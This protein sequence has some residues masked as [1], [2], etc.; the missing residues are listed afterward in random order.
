MTRR[1]HCGAGRQMMDGQLIHRSVYD[2][3][4]NGQLNAGNRGRPYIPKTTL[5][6]GQLWPAFVEKNKDNDHIWET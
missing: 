3:I 2:K 1:P 5:P 6:N 4:V